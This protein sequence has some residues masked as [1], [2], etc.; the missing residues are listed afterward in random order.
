LTSDT[1]TG[2]AHY[3]NH[4]QG[5]DIH[6]TGLLDECPRCL[7]HANFPFSELDKR[8]VDNLLTRIQDNLPP[9]SDTEGIAMAKVQAYITIARLLY[10]RYPEVITTNA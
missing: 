10:N 3:N 5:L 9:R 1:H 2:P 4:V 6:D 7:H 8:M